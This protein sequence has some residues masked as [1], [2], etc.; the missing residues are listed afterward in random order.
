M[1]ERVKK[2]PAASAGS[3]EPKEGYWAWDNCTW[4][5]HRVNCYPGGCPYRV[6]AKD[7]KVIREEIACPYPYPLFHDHKVPDYN[8]RGCQKG[9]Q[10]SKA[11]YGPDRLLV[12]MKRVGERGS[13]KWEAIQWE[14]AFD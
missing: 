1:R 9:L 8:P 4:G 13:G 6:Y 10:H 12:P 7:G 5:T 2:E 11:M 14:Q 3:G